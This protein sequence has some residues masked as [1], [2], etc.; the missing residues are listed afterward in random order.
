MTNRNVPHS[1]K[2]KYYVLEQMGT[3]V[4]LDEWLTFGKI[5]GKAISRMRAIQDRGGLSYPDR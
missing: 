5:K 3:E 2:Q 4:G 1:P